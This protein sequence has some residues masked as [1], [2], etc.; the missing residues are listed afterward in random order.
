MM[1]KATMKATAVAKYCTVSNTKHWHQRTVDTPDTGSR[2][3]IEHIPHYSNV[4]GVCKG[5]GMG[6]LGRPRHTSRR[7]DSIDYASAEYSAVQYQC[8]AHS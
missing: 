1:R 6:R 3:R 8:K 5:R 7:R 2:N 4:S